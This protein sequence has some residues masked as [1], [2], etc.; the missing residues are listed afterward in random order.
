MTLPP[1]L[2]LLALPLLLGLLLPSLSSAEDIDGVAEHP[3]ISRYPGQQI[4]WQVIE[5]FRSYRVPTGPVTGYRAIDDW[6]DTAGRVTRTFYR[7]E[8]TD[9]GYAEIYQNY[10]SAL[11]AQGFEIL[12]EGQSADR[13]GAGAGSRQWQ[14]VLYRANPTTQPGEVGTLFAGTASS[15]G[16]GSIVARKTRAAGT[17]YV[18]L[19]VEQHAEDYVGTLI[20]IVEEQAVETGLVVVDPEA[21]GADLEE[22]GRV[23]LRGIVFEFDKATLRSESDAALEVIAGYLAAHPQRSFY[24]VG[25]S[26]GVGTFAYNRQLSADRARAVVTALTTR[27][28]IAAERLVPHGVGPLAPVFSNASEA[29][30]EQNRRVELVE[31]EAGR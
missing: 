22:Y 27:Y 6:I 7:Y 13:R 9:R 18:V 19:T 25:H 31:I 21:M 12:A 10:L 2:A 29:G 17:A 15:G 3:M 8:G 28:G 24:V 14:E 16:A 23:V 4:R 26:D 1:G 30:R 20:D 5:N 11:K